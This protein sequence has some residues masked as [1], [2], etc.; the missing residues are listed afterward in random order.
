MNEHEP[1][2]RCALNIRVYALSAVICVAMLI[3]S[4]AQAA[5]RYWVATAAADWNVTDNWSTTSAGTGGASVPG[6]ADIAFFDGAGGKNGDCRLDVAITVGGFRIESGYSGSVRQEALTLTITNAFYQAGGVFAGG[7]AD[8]STSAGF[9][10]A[11]G[12]FTNTSGILTVAFGSPIFSFTGGSFSHNNGTLRFN[13]TAAAN[14]NSVYAIDIQKP[15]TLKHLVYD[16]GNNNSGYYRTYSNTL[17]GAGQV[18]VEGDF[19]MNP[20]RN[21]KADS[22]AIEVRGNITVGPRA[23]SGTTKLLINGTGNQTYT[24]TGGRLPR[25]SVNKPSGSFAPAVGTTDLSSFGFELISGAFVAPAG[26]F[27][28]AELNASVTLFSF[29]GGTYDA[30]NG[31]LQ[32]SWASSTVASRTETIYLRAPLTL[33]H[34][35]YTGGHSQQYTLSYM[36]DIAGSGSLTV[37]GDLKIQQN[38]ANR[39]LAV[40]GGTMEVRGNVEI[41][42]GAS[43][44]TTAIK[45]AGADPQNLTRTDG[46]PPAGS[47]TIDKTGGAVNLATSFSLFGAAQD[48]LWNAGNLN[49]SSNTF[50]IGRH[51]TIGAGAK[52]LGV[53]VADAVTAGRLTVAGTASGINNVGL[54]VLVTGPKTEVAGQTYTILSNNVALNSAFASVAW[55]APWKG[56]VAYTAN[57]SKN[58]TIFDLIQGFPGSIFILQ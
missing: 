6:S 5:N 49:L 28:I 32:F 46:T 22:G 31:T 16:G 53:T 39:L 58:V 33:R 35:I 11:G 21:L 18:V 19:S 13:C 29:T 38:A 7:T 23:Y 41:G 44:G 54:E 30:N 47:W 1:S 20:S 26:I 8:I 40:N 2:H 12:V 52:T 36:N 56:T 57:S 48:L 42:I 51:L 43:G 34:L 15:L 25:V 10:L 24:S 50:T 55:G 17:S 3:G 27:D 45:L 37:E 4:V 9:T 14:N